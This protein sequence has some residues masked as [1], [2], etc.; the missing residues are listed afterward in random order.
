MASSPVQIVKPAQREMAKIS[1]MRFAWDSG[2]QTQD[3]ISEIYKRKQQL[4]PFLLVQIPNSLHINL[5]LY[6]SISFYRCKFVL[7]FFFSF[8]IRKSHW[9][10]RVQIKIHFVTESILWMKQ[11]G[12]ALAAT[13][14]KWPQ[15]FCPIWVIGPQSFVESDQKHGL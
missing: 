15:P 14:S 13:I 1:Y 7:A 10:N 2:A 5:L 6:I 9:K 8:A 12:S 4:L 3:R 11:K